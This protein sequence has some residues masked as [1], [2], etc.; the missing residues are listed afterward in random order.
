[1]SSELRT[2]RIGELAKRIEAGIGA[3]PE[4]ELG[5]MEAELNR[6]TME[7]LIEKLN[8]ASDVYYNSGKELIS[9]YEYDTM[10]DKLV[11]LE[12]QTGITLPD[13]PTQRVSPAVP[14]LDFDEELEGINNDTPERL[15]VVTALKRVKH[16]YPALSLDK[17]KDIL[18]FL[19]IFMDP[20]VLMWKM[21]GSTVVLTY[22]QGHLFLAATRGL[23]GEIGQ[24]ITHNAPYIKGIPMDIP[25]KGK[26]ILRGEAAMSYA[27][28][29]RII[30][31]TEEEYKNPRNLANATITMLD[32]REMRKREIWFHAF[33]L[34]YCDEEIPT[35][36]ADQLATLH[37]WGFNCVE[38]VY[39][40]NQKE[41]QQKITEFT[42]RAKEYAFPVD[43][44]VVASNDARFAESQ[45]GTGHHPNKLVGYAL[46][47]EDEVVETTL[48]R[49]EWSPSRTGLINPVA[50]FEPVELEGTTV[51]RA[52][53]H[54]V[55]ILKKLRLRVGD[56][57]GV[58]KANKIIPQIAENRTAG[59]PLT[60]TESHVEYC[61]CCGKETVPKITGSG[62][63]A[64]EVV[65][66]DNPECVVKHIKKFV[67]FCE[68]DC[69][70]IEGLS[71]KTITK[72]VEKGF[73]HEL[74]DIYKLD[75]YENEI[76][77]MDGFGPKAFQNLMASIEKSK[78][79]SFVPF[80]HALGIPGIGK[81][82]AKLL[83]AEYSG[84]VMNFFKKVYSRAFFVT[85]NGIGEVL[86]DNL[87]K[88][89]NEHLR[90]IPLYQSSDMPN[91]ID[92]DI[93][94][95]LHYLKFEELSASGNSLSGKTFVITGSLNRFANRDELIALIESHGG[96]VSGS[97]SAKTSFLINNDVLSTS[98]K[99]K[100]AKELNIPII[101][102]E[103]FM[104]MIS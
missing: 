54:N 26:L 17:T 96:K 28:F 63:G 4:N 45:P 68:R 53:I 79:T 59:E 70:N 50:V 91:G 35:T 36:F 32:S 78:T 1:M 65:M 5:D 23:N 75:K 100:K 7:E 61:P 44:L 16:E 41:L 87:W 11:V 33:K 81:G 64:T 22:D 12:K 31:E 99:N 88:W 84:N 48:T 49:I 83:C 57:I 66:C 43:G 56:R 47:W 9:N 93:Y 97:V 52:S 8:K 25:C 69:M 92:L 82:Q 14:Q 104:N 62:E 3:L 80:V 94:K 39:V 71:E 27:E 20:S 34:V 40:D 15:E 19:K 2:Q 21:D 13:S 6:L 90:W 98:G 72:F 67:H 89:G 38:N 42:N 55:S 24:D 85:I 18:E 74:S 86:Q 37:E 73:I 77:A 58:Y 51:S 29:D 102:E 60:Y 30:A 101:S 46:K 103:L 95:V 10:Y 76:C